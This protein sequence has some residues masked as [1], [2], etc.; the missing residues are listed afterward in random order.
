MKIWPYKPSKDRWLCDICGLI[1]IEK[2]VLKAPN[3]FN[4]SETVWGCP[5][6]KCAG[7][8]KYVCEAIGCRNA[9]TL[10]F[11]IEGFGYGSACDDHQPTQSLTRKRTKRTKGTNWKNL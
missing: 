1:T 9:V 2:K 5:H 10:G 8:F 4:K 7:S 6:C 3:P 11:H